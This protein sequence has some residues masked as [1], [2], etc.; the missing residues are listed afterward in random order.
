MENSLFELLE[1]PESWP[2]TARAELLR[3]AER[4]ER[5]KVGLYKMSSEQ[6][7]AVELGLADAK[8]GRIA[9]DSEMEYFSSNAAVETA[10]Y[11]SST[12]RPF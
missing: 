5:E 9:S 4:I 12:N 11:T 7:A 3:A 8:A 10:L 1:R 2:E 6:R